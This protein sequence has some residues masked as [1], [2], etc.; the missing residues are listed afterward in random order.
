[1]QDDYDNR[2]KSIIS[3]RIPVIIV[4]QHLADKAM[5]CTSIKNIIERLSQKNIP[6]YKSIPLACK[7]FRIHLIPD[8]DSMSHQ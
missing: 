7:H 5:Q 3:F 8:K 1:M 2:S 4:S 6:E